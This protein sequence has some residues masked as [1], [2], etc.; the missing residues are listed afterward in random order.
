MA[1]KDIGHGWGDLPPWLTEWNC[2]TCGKE[3]PINEWQVESVQVK[4]AMLDGRKCPACGWIAVQVG[5]TRRMLE[6]DK[7]AMEF[8]E[9]REKKDKA[10]K[11]K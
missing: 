11:V 10:G 1:V 5:D 9:D 6:V 3:A 2:P 4:S 8:I 7:K